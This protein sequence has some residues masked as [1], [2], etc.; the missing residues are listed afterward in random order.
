MSTAKRR[1]TETAP[2]EEEGRLDFSWM[3]RLEKGAPPRRKR[4]R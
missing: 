2:R 1:K 3:T 4:E